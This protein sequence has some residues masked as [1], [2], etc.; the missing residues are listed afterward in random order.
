[1]VSH[2]PNPDTPALYFDEDSANRAVVEALRD[3]GY[4]VLST[5]EAGNEGISD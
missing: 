3:E 4:D 2:N 1:M 5:Y